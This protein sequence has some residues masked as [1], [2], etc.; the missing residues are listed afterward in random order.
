MLN[1]SIGQ[2]TFELSVKSCSKITELMHIW[3]SCAW[4]GNGIQKQ[5]TPS[6]CYNWYLECVH[7]F[8]R[9]QK[10]I[11]FE[12]SAFPLTASTYL[13]THSVPKMHQQMKLFLSWNCHIWRNFSFNF[14]YATSKNNSKVCYRNISIRN[15]KKKSL[16]FGIYISILQLSKRYT[17]TQQ[18]FGNA[19][20]MRC[21]CIH[22][23]I[24]NYRLHIDSEVI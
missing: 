19:G 23:A 8:K 16:R 9:R 7:V 5:K 14:Q 24:L 10:F 2:N 13:T 20:K 22:L 3:E 17:D 15:V 18:I 12:C 11:Y 1:P 6:V 4:G 21:Y